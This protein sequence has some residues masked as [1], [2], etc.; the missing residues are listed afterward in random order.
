MNLYGTDPLDPDTDD[1]GFL[2][3]DE[4]AIGTDPL[5]PNDNFDDLPSSEIPAF[6]PWGTAVLAS[7]FLLAA[8]LVLRA[9]PKRTG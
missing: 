6:G 1:D 3:G 7:L 8:F 4:V 5:D 2:D 9:R